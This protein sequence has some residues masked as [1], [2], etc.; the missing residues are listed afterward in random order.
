LH[1]VAY[2]LNPQFHYEPEVKEGL[3]MS[4]RRL[5]KDVVERRKINV[6]LVEYHFG[7]GT[8]AIEDAKETRKNNTSW[9][10][11]GDV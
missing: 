4:M 1:A 2:Y 3:Y 9:R 8:F 10:M 7:R 5:A 11:V 6:Q